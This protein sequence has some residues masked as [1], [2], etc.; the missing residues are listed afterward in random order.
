MLTLIYT[1]FSLTLLNPKLDNWSA[2]KKA[3]SIT[4]ISE[5]YDVNWKLITAILFQESSLQDDPQG[6][7]RGH[8]GPDKGIGQVR[9]SVWQ[10]ELNLNV[11]QLLVDSDYAIKTTGK[12]INYYKKR[13]GKKELKWYSRYHSSKTY[14]RRIYEKKIV[15]HINKID[16]FLANY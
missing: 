3:V 4:Q 11:K 9:I 7:L 13:F 14:F 12:I 16:K 5:K 2:I 6:C 1:Y 8:C 15:N 10:K